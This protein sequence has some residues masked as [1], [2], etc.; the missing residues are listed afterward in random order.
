LFAQLADGTIEKTTRAEELPQRGG[1]LSHQPVARVITDVYPQH[2]QSYTEQIS[3]ELTEA[4]AA[5]ISLLRWRYSGEGSDRPLRA[6][7]SDG[8]S[9]DGKLWNPLPTSL[10]VSIELELDEESVLWVQSARASGAAEPLA[11]GLFREA[12]ALGP[13]N[14][15]T[16][17][18]IGM[19]AAE[20]GFKQFVAECVP[21][22]EWLV[23]EIQSPPLEKML[24]EYLPSLPSTVQPSP[25]P[26]S[27]L[28]SL[29]K[30]STVRNQAIHRGLSVRMDTA[31]EVLDS[32]RDLL[33]MLDYFRGFSW[34]LD[35][36]RTD[37]R[38]EWV[39][40]LAQQSRGAPSEPSP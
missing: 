4:A 12:W 15:R 32:V 18:I 36:V 6:I 3:R 38:D 22:A 7:L 16:A 2:V 8:F 20:I 23:E 33:W 1:A 30:G 28:R 34:A 13:T 5:V 31:L 10:G 26:E 29:R 39:K 14:P 35:Y 40:G 19:A 25:P 17:L 9:F 24:K 11:H 27:L 37:V 21:A